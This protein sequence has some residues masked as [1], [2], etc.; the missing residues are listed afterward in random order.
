MS[1]ICLNPLACVSLQLLDPFMTL[2]IGHLPW[3]LVLHVLLSQWLFFHF[4]IK[5]LG[6]E[7]NYI[8]W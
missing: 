4:G 7:R 2:C 6:N 3:Q 1:M 5:S 8:T